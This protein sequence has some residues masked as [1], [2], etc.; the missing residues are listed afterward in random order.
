MGEGYWVIR[1][2]E[3][4]SIGEKVKYWVSGERPP[5]NAKKLKTEVNKQT[6]NENCAIK[7]LARL[8]NLNFP[9]GNGGYLVRLGYSDDGVEYIG[10]EGDGE[11]WADKLY[12]AAHHQLR[13]WL[14]R[15]RRACQKDGVPFRYVAITS[16][17]DG[18]TGEYKRV[19]HHIVMN[20]EAVEIA[21]SKWELGS[22]HNKRLWRAHDL[23]GL[24]EYLMKQVRRLPDEKKYI[25]S[26]NLQQPK[27]KD[28][29]AKSGAEIGV[30]RGGRLLY[31]RE[32]RI[33]GAQYI[34]YITA[35][36]LAEDQDDT[37][38]EWGA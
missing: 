19:H 14:R 2:W 24:A 9:K 16:D 21:L 31:R 11:E 30:P 29:I 28:R 13:L 18:K 1:T 17:R 8:L 25:P 6:V 5:K 10:G 4:G 22:T 33:G 20:Q 32:F 12:R 27:P 7:R 34:R 36:D 3:T 15:V 26:R 35:K 37:P 38:P 23:S